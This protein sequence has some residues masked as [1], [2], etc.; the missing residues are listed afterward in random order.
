MLKSGRKGHYILEYKGEVLN[1]EPL[2]FHDLCLEYIFQQMVE[3][4]DPEHFRFIDSEGKCWSLELVPHYAQQQEKEGEEGVP[5]A[6][7]SARS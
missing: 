2:S 6:S 5:L 1:N 3:G 7:E 4:R